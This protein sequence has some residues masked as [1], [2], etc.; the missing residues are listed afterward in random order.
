MNVGVG[1]TEGKWNVPSFWRKVLQ[2]RNLSCGLI[3][4]K[5]PKCCAQAVG[6]AIGQYWIFRLGVDLR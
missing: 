3:I 2:S 6:S 5:P 1:V 4:P